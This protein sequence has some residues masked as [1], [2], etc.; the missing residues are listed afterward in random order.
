[1]DIETNR[2][3]KHDDTEKGH[4]NRF[5]IARSDWNQYLQNYQF[6]KENIA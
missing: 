1:V 5:S 4:S 6:I 3:K 2:N